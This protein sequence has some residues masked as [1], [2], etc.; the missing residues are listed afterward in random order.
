MRV[1]SVSLLIWRSHTCGTPSRPPH[2]R[3]I[4]DIR[5]T[6]TVVDTCLPNSWDISGSRGLNNCWTE[7]LSKVVSTIIKSEEENEK[8]TRLCK[9]TNLYLSENVPNYSP[10]H[11]VK[12]V[13]LNILLKYNRARKTGKPK[14]TMDL[15]VVVSVPATKDTTFIVTDGSY[16][17]YINIFEPDFI[18]VLITDSSL[19]SYK[20]RM[21]QL[22]VPR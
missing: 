12:E 19:E 16:Y 11:S 17:F 9:T 2:T 6:L 3:D 5:R 7:G 10:Y 21:Y 13:L 8:S 14:L 1:Y 4:L 20:L 22:C 18:G 15:P